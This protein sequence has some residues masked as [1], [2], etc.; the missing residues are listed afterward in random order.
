MPTSAETVRTI[1][2]LIEVFA[3]AVLKF[4]VLAKCEIYFFC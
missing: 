1:A 4:N 2:E 3:Y